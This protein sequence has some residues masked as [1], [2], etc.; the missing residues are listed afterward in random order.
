MPDGTGNR[1]AFFRDKGTGLFFQRIAKGVIG[2]QEEPA[3]PAFLHQGAARA[4][5]QGVGVISPVETIGRTLRA[6][7]LGRRSPR[8]HGDL[9]F[10]GGQSLNGE[11]HRGCGQLHDAVHLF[12]VIPLARD[13]RRDVGLVLVV[14]GHDLDRRVHNLAAEILDRHQGGFIGILTAKVGINA[15]LVVQNADL[16]GAVRYLGHGRCGNQAD[17]RGRQQEFTHSTSLGHDPSML[18]F[19]P[20]L[21]MMSCP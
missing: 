5:S 1:A 10:L 15:G 2:G 6:G 21:G 20:R 7:Q 9:L 12:G 16:D 3:V 14:G 11:R 13:V 17:R 8:G 18:R 19:V 4:H